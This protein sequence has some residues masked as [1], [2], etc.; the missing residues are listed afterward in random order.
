MV[1]TVVSEDGSV[2][3]WDVKERK[4]VY[5]VNHHQG[6]VLCVSITKDNRYFAAGSLD[7]TI[8]ICKV[9]DGSLQSKLTAHSGSVT[10]LAFSADGKLLY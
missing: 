1:E 10:S 9:K 8:S 5:A 3:M 7:N 2:I 6:S 4:P